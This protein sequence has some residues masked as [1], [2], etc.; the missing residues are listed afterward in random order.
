MSK[1]SLSDAFAAAAPLPS[2]TSHLER[3]EVIDDLD[4]IL[5]LP[6]RPPLDCEIRDFVAADGTVTKRYTPKA[7]ALIRVMTSRLGRGKRV[8]CACRPR[9]V[10]ASPGGVLQ[11][12]RGVPDDFPPEPPVTVNLAAFVADNQANAEE[13]AAA[14]QVSRLRAG[15]EILLP[16]ADEDGHACI[17]VLNAVQAWSLY[18]I[19]KE[20]GGLGFAG[21]GSGKSIFFILLPIALGA[22]CRLAVLLI[23]PNQRKH[24]VSQ[25][26]RVREH[27][28]VPSIIFE[29]GT[30]PYI[31][32]GATTLH[33]LPYSKLGNPKHPD[34][35]DVLDPNVIGADEGHRLTGKVN[36]TGRN[37]VKRYIAKKIVEREAM[38][39]AGKQVFRRAVYLIPMS[40]TLED[41]SVADVQPV[42]A[43]ALGMNSPHPLDAVEAAKWVPVFDPVRVADRTSATARRLQQ[44]F[45]GRL[46]EGDT[47]LDVAAIL[48]DE[49]PEKAIREGFQKRRIETPGVISAS[50]AEVGA[51]LYFRERKAPK[52]PDVVAQALKKVREEGVRPDGEVIV[53]DDDNNVEAMVK[54][55][56]KQ[57]AIGMY[58]YWAYPN[59]PCTCGG[60]DPR[61]DGCKLIDE[62]FL[63]R[64]K[65]FRELRA[66]LLRPFNATGNRADNHLD[67]PK[68]CEN[69]ARRAQ[70][71]PSPPAGL[72][73]YCAN[74]REEWPC[75]KATHLPAWRSTHWK[76]WSE[77]EDKVPHDQR[78]RWIGH[79]LPEAKDPTT[80]PGYYLA[81]DTVKWGQENTGVIWYQTIAYGEKVAQLGR[82]P[83]HGGGPSGEE[84]LRAERGDR[85]IVVS[86]K[87]WGKGFDGLQHYFWKQFWPEMPSSNKIMEQG[88]GRLLRRGQKNDSV[89]SEYY[90][91][92][93]ELREALRRVRQRAEFNQSMMGR[94]QLILAATFE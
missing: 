85:S 86:L 23:E 31:V 60:E 72:S 67:S 37:R 92:V 1:S 3:V 69:A 50:A 55:V 26:R 14:Q 91:H 34:E 38:K 16:A 4:R 12:T 36:S 46:W 80:H 48:N 52:M 33:L 63:R 19:P 9:V 21:V 81:R 59:V 28:R 2:S 35:L 61:C 6:R 41:K 10:R 64:K 71:D 77:I 24:Y 22:E 73:V 90:A 68:L 30:P 82:L 84:A 15:D 62:W 75:G 54:I 42:A 74:C 93:V 94:P 65:Y 18:E 45:A 39:A 20:A 51:S 8:S 32:P 70:E 13:I 89:L 11:I 66:W 83:Y 76:L 57:I 53:G 49:G 58:Y 5:A 7:E 79:D 47:L 25:Y 40:G 29:D 56:A 43:H 17:D 27:F 88:L 44:A 87:S 78:V